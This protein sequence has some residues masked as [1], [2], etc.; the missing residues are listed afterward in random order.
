[1]KPKEFPFLTKPEILTLEQVEKLDKASTALWVTASVRDRATK[2]FPFKRWA[3]LEKD[4]GLIRTLVVIGGGTMIDAAKIWSH[5]RPGK[6]KLVAIPSIWGSG[7]EASPIAVRNGGQKKEIFLGEGYLPTARAIWPELAETVTSER[8]I[9]ACGDCWAHALEGFLSPLAKDASRS[10][11]ARLIQEMLT[12]KSWKDAKWYEWSAQA[13]AGQAQSSVGLVH[14]I[15]HVLEGVLAAQEPAGTWGHAHL[16]A[17]LL[18]P[19]MRFNTQSSDYA[20]N[21][22]QKHGLSGEAIL[23]QLKKMHD[24]EAYRILLPHLRQHWLQILR[25]PCSRTNSTLA[26]PASLDFF[27]GDLS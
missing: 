17:V 5:E 4:P 6:I 11:L 27:L 7:A 21:L 22:F 14:G 8:A 26:R 12:A 18:Y 24:P 13:C 1:M 16:C 3:Q 9:H 25:D 20:K 2:K 15:A 23:T 10:Q 19:V